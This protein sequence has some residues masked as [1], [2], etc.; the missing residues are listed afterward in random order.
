MLLEIITIEIHCL[1]SL[2]LVEATDFK[3]IMLNLSLF[4][5]FVNHFVISAVL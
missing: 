1:K 4:L 2:F 3:R 5:D